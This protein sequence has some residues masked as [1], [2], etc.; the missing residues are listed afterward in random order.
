MSYEP[1][2]REW[3]K[4]QL[5]ELFLLAVNDHAPHVLIELGEEPFRLFLEAGLHGT[6]PLPWSGMEGLRLYK[7]LGSELP[8]TES[9]MWKRLQHIESS[10]AFCEALLE[11]AAKYNLAASWVLERGMWTLLRWQQKGRQPGF[12]GERGWSLLGA[13]GTTPSKLPAPPGLVEYGV[14]WNRA[15]YLQSV[16]SVMRQRFDEVFKQYPELSYGKGSILNAYIQSV[17][18]SS[19]IPAKYCDRSDEHIKAHGWVESE[20]S[21]NLDRDIMWAVQF[22]VMKWDFE[23]IATKKIAPKSLIKKYVAKTYSVSTVSRAVVGYTPKGKPHV[24]GFLEKIGLARR[25]DSGAGRRR[26]SK[27]SPN[28]W[29]RSVKRAQVLT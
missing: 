12:S 28:S 8:K 2:S 24:S 14:F 7:W 10:K 11:W 16:E 21:R 23:K 29:R 18:D 26:G 9:P 13:G 4:T 25:P 17:K 3:S 27:E 19:S 1:P 6:T 5:R 22:Q 20:R 15:N